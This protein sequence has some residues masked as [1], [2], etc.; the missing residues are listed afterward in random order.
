MRE[1]GR[2]GKL[3]FRI[4]VERE[5]TEALRELLE[6][7]ARLGLPMRNRVLMRRAL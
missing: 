6:S 1:W 5:L 7:E 3:G 2:S 4:L